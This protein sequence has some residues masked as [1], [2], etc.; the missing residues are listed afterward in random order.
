LI[1]IPLTAVAASMVTLWLA[2][3]RPDHLVVDEATYNTLRSELKT[4]QPTQ[5]DQ[6]R[7]NQPRS[8]QPR[9]GQPRSGEEPGGQN[10]ERHGQQRRNEPDASPETEY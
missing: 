10:D 6:P 7:S 1:A 3:T 2:I 9:S 5:S 8:G 4:A